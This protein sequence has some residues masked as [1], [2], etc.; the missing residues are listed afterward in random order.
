MLDDVKDLVDWEVQG[1]KVTKP[2]A[3]TVVEGASS[4]GARAQ[5]PLTHFLELSC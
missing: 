1:V 3:F 4:L 2:S 5:C